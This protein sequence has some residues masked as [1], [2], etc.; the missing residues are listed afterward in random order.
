MLK[1]KAKKLKHL[2]AKELFGPG[3]TQFVVGGVAR[4]IDTDSITQKDPTAP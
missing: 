4:Q 3:R 1:L 2:T